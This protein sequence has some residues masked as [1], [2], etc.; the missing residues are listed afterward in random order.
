MIYTTKSIESLNDQ[1]RKMTSKRGSIPTEGSVR[2][3]SYLASTR[4]AKEWR[5]K[6]NPSLI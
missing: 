5:F 1:L 2:E 4:V 3:L 6:K